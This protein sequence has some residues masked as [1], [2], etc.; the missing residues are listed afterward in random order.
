MKQPFIEWI[1]NISEI[2][3]KE[4]KIYKNLLDLEI[5][6]KG[7]ILE[8][9]GKALESLTKESYNLMVGASELERVRMNE[10][11]NFYKEK[12]IEISEEKNSFNEFLNHIDRNSNFKL[13]GLAGE[14]KEVLQSLKEKII[15]NEKL[16][17]TNQEI[18]KLSI[19]A[20]KRA[21]ETE[22]PVSYGS[23]SVKTSTRNTPVM[24]N[25]KA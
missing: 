5:Q 20:L 11:E 14:L 17:K 8:K 13:K 24:L 4:I 2:F 3:T 16:M 15:L 6:K 9:N 18:F 25:T 19:D 1:S 23:V 12:K 21:S 10:I 22:I 7:N